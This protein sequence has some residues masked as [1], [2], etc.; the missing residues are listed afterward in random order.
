MVP[1]IM[2][3]FAILFAFFQYL[4]NHLDQNL[5]FLMPSDRYTVPAGAKSGKIAAI[6]DSDPFW[7]QPEIKTGRRFEQ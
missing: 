1:C 5:I 6:A 3:F 7:H 2:M 4:P